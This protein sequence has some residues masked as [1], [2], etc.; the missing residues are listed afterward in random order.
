MKS[1]T[2]C[3]TGASISFVF[4]FCIFS[5]NQISVLKFCLATAANKLSTFRFFFSFPFFRSLSREQKPTHCV[6]MHDDFVIEIFRVIEHSQKPT[7]LFILY[8]HT[9]PAALYPNTNVSIALANKCF[10]RRRCCVMVMCVCFVSVLSR[11]WQRT[12]SSN[13]MHQDVFLHQ[14]KC[15]EV[16]T[17]TVL[18]LSSAGKLF[19]KSNSNVI[20]KHFPN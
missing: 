13:V 19:S 3:G 14:R 18:L 10:W 16:K 8:A 6:A 17:A 7:I 2:K 5:Y 9:L 1:T 12:R 11:R 15:V 4:V 20:Y